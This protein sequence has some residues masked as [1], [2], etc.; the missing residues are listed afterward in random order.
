MLPEKK[1][2]ILSFKYAFEGIFAALKEEPNLKIHILIS[3][4]VLILSYFL[5][6]SKQDWINI[7]LIIGFVFAVELTNT[8]IEAVV[9]AFTEKEHPG[10]KLIKDISAGAV[11]V[12]ALTSV[13]LGLMIFIPYLMRLWI[14]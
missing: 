2:H 4:L 11:L 14:I 5:Q 12:A 9:D 13:V 8:A 1:F 7:I 6:I 3:I 10:A